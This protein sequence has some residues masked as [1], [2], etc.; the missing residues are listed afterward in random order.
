MFRNLLC[1]AG[2]LLLT[3]CVMP[4]TTASTTQSEAAAPAAAGTPAALP[5][6][7]PAPELQNEV[8][9]NTD[10]QQLRLAQLR[11]QVVLL[12]MWTYS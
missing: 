9:L 11:G 10:G 12:D 2:A 5:D 4:A 6:L 1:A 8:F 3:A 7:G